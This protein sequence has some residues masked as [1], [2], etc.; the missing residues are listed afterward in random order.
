[1]IVQTRERFNAAEMVT[2]MS[3]LDTEGNTSLAADILLQS[4]KVV[5][6]SHLKILR[7]TLKDVNRRGV[8]KDVVATILRIQSKRS[9]AD[10]KRAY[11][12]VKA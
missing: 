11:K 12:K 9:R 6:W 8:P 4:D 2:I 10:A 1:M 3:M 5:P 7:R